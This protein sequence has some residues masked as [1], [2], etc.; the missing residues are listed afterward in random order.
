MALAVKI[1]CNGIKP[2]KAQVYTLAAE[3]VMTEGINGFSAAIINALKSYEYEYD[4][5]YGYDHGYGYDHYGYGYY[6]NYSLEEKVIA[7]LFLAATYSGVS[8]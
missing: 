1:K 4:Y 8:D 2:T 3:L 7:L 6:N 5:D